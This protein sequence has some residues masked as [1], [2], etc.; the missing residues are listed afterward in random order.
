MDEPIRIKV[1][2]P[3]GGKTTFEAYEAC[4]D[5][6]E[7]YRY[8]HWKAYRITFHRTPEPSLDIVEVPYQDVPKTIG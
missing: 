3:D 4:P 5:G 1:E 6:Y 2:W 7:F 8:R